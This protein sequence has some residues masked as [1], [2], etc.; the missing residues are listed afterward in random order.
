MEPTS[1]HAH[2]T[3]FPTTL[4]KPDTWEVVLRAADPLRRFSHIPAV[5]HNGFIINFPPI[6][7]VQIPPN[8]ES[9]SLYRDEFI[10]TL[11]KEV[12]KNRY[13]RPF[14]TSLL[15]TL[16]GPFQSSPISIVPKP[17]HPGKFKLVQN[18]SYPLFPSLQFPNSS[19]NSFINANDFLTTWGTFS[20]VYLLISHL[21]P[22]SEAATR[23]V[24][25]AYRMIPLHKSQWPSAVVRTDDDSFYVDTCMAF[26]V[27]PSVGM[28]GAVADAGAEIL[29]H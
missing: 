1:A 2:R 6:S 14:T 17:G 21:P 19:I 9:V 29:R 8:K 3:C 15:S 13:L 28:Y 4:Y 5:F 11:D 16:I 12:P 10:K 23:D 18:F 7:H 26:G 25:E 27:T 20:I 24:A 22:N